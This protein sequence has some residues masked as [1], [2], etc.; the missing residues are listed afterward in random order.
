MRRII[1]ALAIGLGVVATERLWAIYAVPNAEAALR[2][3]LERI[4][5]AELSA[6][7]VQRP[8]HCRVAGFAGWGWQAQCLRTLKEYPPAQ[9]TVNSWN[10]DRWGN[11]SSTFGDKGPMTG[12]FTDCR[13]D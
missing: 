1:V 10:I 7:A 5:R 13:F 11:P 9:C 2:I 3:S 12:I 4:G 8:E 6:V